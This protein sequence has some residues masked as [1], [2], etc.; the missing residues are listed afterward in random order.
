MADFILNIINQLLCYGDPTVT[1]NPH[2]RAI[3]HRRRMESLPVKNPYQNNLVLKPGQ[4]FK[5][6]ENS[7]TVGLDST[8]VLDLTLASPSDSIYK[9]KIDSGSGTFKTQKSVTGL[10]SCNVTINN[11]ALAVFDYSGADL[12]NVEVGDIMRISGLKTYSTL[13]SFAFNPLNSGN[14]T[15]I[16]VS[17]TKI[18]AIRKVTSQFEGVTEFVADSSLDVIFYSDDLLSEGNKLSISGSFSPASFSV[19]EIKDVT[20]TELFIMSSMPIPEETSVSYL[21]DSMVFYTG[22]K[23]LIYIE[24][25]QECVIRFDNGMDNSNKVSP[26]KAGDKTLP[27]YLHKWGNTYSC[28]IINKSITNCNIKYFTCE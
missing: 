18:S 24:A 26:V 1:D 27:G 2:M 21:S 15:V 10:S 9:L 28:E 6:F 25:D 16:G 20:P 7:L 14:W 8:S 3:D 19:Y 23:K 5:I 17:G 4:S 12:S 11:N 22:T 13:P